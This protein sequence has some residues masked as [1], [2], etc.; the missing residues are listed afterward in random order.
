[1]LFVKYLKHFTFFNHEQSARRNRGGRPHP[2]RLTR[3]TAFTE[4]VAGA[5]NRDDRFFADFTNDGEL[6]ASC[7]QVNYTLS[8]ISLG[9][10]DLRSFKLSN[11]SCHGG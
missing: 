4:K 5:Q 1:M 3:Q 2:N 10:D 7:F 8:G 6:H 11:F 9:V